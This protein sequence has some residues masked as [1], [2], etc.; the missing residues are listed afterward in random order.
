MVSEKL[1]FKITVYFVTSAYR[2][3]L[4]NVETKLQDKNVN[5]Q[6]DRVSF[7]LQI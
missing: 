7:D 2:S 5:K 6:K 1:Q 4:N 3:I